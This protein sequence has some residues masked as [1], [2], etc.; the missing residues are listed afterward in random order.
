MKPLVIVGI[1]P[2]TTS[3]C[4]ILDLD[5]NIMAIH[6]AKEFGLKEM[7]AAVFLIGKPILVGT[8]KAKIPFFVHDFAAKTGARLV[9]PEE[10][11]KKEEKRGLLEQG[12]DLAHNDHESDA[13]AVAYYAFKRYQPRLQKIKRYLQEYHL[14]HKAQEF[15]LIA[16][17]EELHF[18]T[19]REILCTPTREHQAIVEAV[20]QEKITK[21]NYLYVYEK[22]NKIQAEKEILQERCLTLQHFC[23]SLDHENK[24]LQK[25]TGSFYE[26]LDSLLKFK[27]ERIKVQAAQIVRLQQEAQKLDQKMKQLQ[28]VINE[29][30]S[31]ILVKKMASLRQ[32]DWKKVEKT[33][34]I[35]SQDLIFVQHPEL[36]SAHVVEQLRQKRV[37]LLLGQKNMLLQ[38]DFEIIIIT[39][40]DLVYETE[41]VA[42]IN[43]LQLEKKI[44]HNTFIEEII[45]EYKKKRG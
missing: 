17:K 20:T 12:Q 9:A 18:T 45:A 11:L 16:L 27:D 31:H 26:R 41:N 15:T 40:P 33:F 43:P 2:G 1:D 13:L 10:D 23:K 39:Q 34:P 6:S 7:I 14:E 21:R 4:A 38:K 25:R 30:R 5:G 29:S 44:K 8:D 37:T 22:M 35:Y 36:Y 19:I 28:T 24:R 42:L 32:E 3:A